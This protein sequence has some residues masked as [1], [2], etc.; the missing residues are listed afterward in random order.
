[1]QKHTLQ[2]SVILIVALIYVLASSVSAHRSGCHRWHSCPSDTGSYV[3]GDLGYPCQYPTYP[4]NG[5]V[6]YPP[7]GWYKDCYECPLKKIAADD[8]RIWKRHLQ[9]GD[10]GL[11]VRHLQEMLIKELVYPEALVTGYF[12]EL[13]ENSVKRFQQKHNIVSDG[14]PMSTGFGRIGWTTLSILNSLYPN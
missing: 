10:S 9:K 2:I 6:I 12:G 5:G 11:D 3:C 7:L 8:A 4:K 13:T 14:D 1:M